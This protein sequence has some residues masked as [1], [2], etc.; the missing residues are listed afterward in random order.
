MHS[1]YRVIK[2]VNVCEVGNK[3]IDSSFPINFICNCNSDSEEVTE[4][5]EGNY[6]EVKKQCEDLI[7]NTHK[8]IEEKFLRAEE[9]ISKSLYESKEAGFKQGYEEG[10]QVGSD[11]GYKKAYEEGLQRNEEIIRNANFILY[12]AKEEYDKYLKAKEME[13]R[14]IIVKSVETMLKKELENPEAL[15]KLLYTI[16]SEEKNA[17]IIIIRVS[18]IYVEELE[19][20][21]KDFTHN[22]G[23]RGEVIILQD[24]FLEEGTLV[25]EKDHGK[26]SFTINNSIEKLR[27]ILMEV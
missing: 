14:D 5:Y 25:V 24:N 3:E 23:I 18:P 10:Y 17:K 12:Q 8:E 13:I 19:S 27:E 11:E 15:N 26:T 1:S 7:E 22:L 9:D 6:A 21:I 16:L 20:I 4:E 2:S